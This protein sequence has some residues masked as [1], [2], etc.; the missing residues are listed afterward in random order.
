MPEKFPVASRC[1]RFGEK[2]GELFLRCGGESEKSFK[3]CQCFSEG[4]SFG[5]YG[6]AF[7]RG[8]DKPLERRGGRGC[9]LICPCTPAAPMAGDQGDECQFFLQSA[10]RK[11]AVARL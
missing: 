11:R 2:R 7:Q 6:F 4:K 8:G 10:V 5:R 1:R 3:A 9:L